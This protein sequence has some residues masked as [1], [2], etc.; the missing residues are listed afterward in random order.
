[1]K[2]PP[3]DFRKALLSRD[4]VL[5]GLWLGLTDSLAVEIVAG[6]G[7]DWLLIDDEHAPFELDTILRH[8]Q[9]LA[10]CDAVPIVRPRSHD[11]AWLKKLLDIGVQNYLVPMV[12]TA[13]Q[14]EDLLS[15]LFYP[16]HGNRGLGTSLAR[17]AQWNRI[18]DY[19]ARANEEVCLIVQAETTLAL[20]NLD[21]ILSVDRVDGVFIGPSDLAASLGYPGQPDRPEV[22]SAV[23]GA[24]KQIVGCGKAAGVLAVTPELAEQYRDMGATF[25]GLGTDTSLLSRAAGELA[26]RYKPGGPSE[27]GAA[28]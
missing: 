7:F 6:A 12:D 13:E 24:I 4:K 18:S 1:M 2:L 11:A 19:I 22:V 27:Q 20:K 8:L 25:I 9:V 5:Y 26:L 21:S 3:N 10:A 23:G 16:P 17:A 28:Y 15:A 14:V